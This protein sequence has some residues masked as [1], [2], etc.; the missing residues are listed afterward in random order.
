MVKREKNYRPN[1]DKE[2]I[3]KFR[4]ENPSIVNNIRNNIR[5]LRPNIDNETLERDTD[6]E[7]LPPILVE[8]IWARNLQNKKQ[9]ILHLSQVNGADRNYVQKIEE[10][11]INIEEREKLWEIIE[12]LEDKDQ[13]IIKM[14]YGLSPYEKSYEKK[15]IAK[16]LNLS[17]NAITN[18]ISKILKFFKEQMENFEIEE[19]IFEY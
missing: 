11:N 18:K 3:K 5:Y 4:E 2:I 15:E 16:A 7:I 12:I 19:G 14:L 13:I 8:P 1:Y 17:Q 9:G 10:V 6:N